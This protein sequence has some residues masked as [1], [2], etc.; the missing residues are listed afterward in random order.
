MSIIANI[1][2]NMSV[3]DKAKLGKSGVK[4][5]SDGEHKLTIKEAYEI[6]SEGGTH[7]RFV[8]KM[9]VRRHIPRED[10]IRVVG[11]WI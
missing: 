7:P 4:V 5:N 6:T 2:N 10:L 11:N 9:E 3:E 8:L 1:L